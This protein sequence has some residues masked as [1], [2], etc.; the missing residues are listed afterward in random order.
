M[1][2]L[3][4]R[5]SGHHSGAPFFFFA[6]VSAVNSTISITLNRV[7][8]SDATT[9]G[10]L[11]YAI[12]QPQRQIARGW[13]HPDGTTGQQ[14]SP[15]SSCESDTQMYQSGPDGIANT[16][17]A[18]Q[19]GQNYSWSATTW[20]SEFGPNYY[21]EVLAHYAGYL[22]SGSSLFL[23]NARGI[24]DYWAANPELD[25][26]YVGVTPRHAGITGMVAGAVLDGRVNNWTTIRKNG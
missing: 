16:S 10:G 13:L 21:D 15:V 22:R 11:T 9:E 2:S 17:M 23:S 25:Q 19:T 12:I 1:T 26:G 3:R 6:T 24:G 20:L 8:P 5:V 4:V 14:L 18:L 7:Y